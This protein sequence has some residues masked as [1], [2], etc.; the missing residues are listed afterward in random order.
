MDKAP[1][2]W[3]WKCE[4]CDFSNAVGIERCSICGLPETH[5]SEQLEKYRQALPELKR[6]RKESNFVVD[7]FRSLSKTILRSFLWPNR[8]S[9]WFDDGPKGK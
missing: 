1:L 6:L 7:F 8:P 2:A 4:C 9:K 5:T 3:M